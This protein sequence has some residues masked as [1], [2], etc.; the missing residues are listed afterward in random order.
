MSR[1]SV[2]NTT[3][4]ASINVNIVATSIANPRELNPE[5]PRYYAVSSSII[6]TSDLK[7]HQ[8]IKI[9]NRITRLLLAYHQATL[10]RSTSPSTSAVPVMTPEGH[11]CGQ[12]VGRS[13]SCEPRAVKASLS[14]HWPCVMRISMLPIPTLR[15]CPAHNR[16]FV[17]WPSVINTA[18]RWVRRALFLH[19]FRPLSGWPWELSVLCDFLHKVIIKCCKNSLRSSL[20]IFPVFVVLRE[21]NTVWMKWFNFNEWTKIN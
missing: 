21:E 2:F 16:L 5:A 13:W 11:P 17:F 8:P 10:H 1:W 19:L 6:K 18:S 3:T 9:I 15:I 12:T 7:F 4:L 14:D 20:F